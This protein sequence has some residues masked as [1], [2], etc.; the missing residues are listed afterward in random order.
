MS[1]IARFL[2]DERTIMAKLKKISASNCD[3]VRN[4]IG[5]DQMWTPQCAPVEKDVR[6][7]ECGI[8]IRKGEPAFTFIWEFSEHRYWRK[9]CV[10]HQNPCTFLVDLLEGKEITNFQHIQDVDPSG[11]KKIEVSFRESGHMFASLHIGAW[12]EAEKARNE[13]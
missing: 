4:G 11:A 12:L 5:G 8:I 2:S 3:S 1:V 9:T 10:I 6:C 13:D 7:R